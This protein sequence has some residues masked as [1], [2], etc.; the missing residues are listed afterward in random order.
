[1]KAV[2]GSAGTTSNRLRARGYTAPSPGEPSTSRSRPPD[3]ASTRARAAT[4]TGTGVTTSA[5]ANATAIAAIRPPTKFPPPFRS[6]TWSHAVAQR[7]TGCPAATPDATRTRAAPCQDALD[8][9]QGVTAAIRVLERRELNRALLERQ[10]LLRRRR[11]SVLDAVEHLVAMQAPVPARSVRRALVP[12]RSVRS[13]VA[14]R[15]DRRSPR[16]AHDLAAGDAPPGDGSR[17]PGPASARAARRRTH[18]VRLEPAPEGGRRRRRRR[19]L[20]A[21]PR[22]ARGATAHTRRARR[23]D[24]GAVAGPRRVVAR[25]LDVP[26]PDGAGHA[27]RTWGR[28]GPSAFTTVERWLGRPIVAGT[29]PDDMLPGTWLRSGPPPSPTRNTGQAS[30]G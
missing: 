1:M 24:P 14:R 23:R 10:M 4:P 3:G 16:R 27:S 30:P 12:T 2:S 26:A 25:L 9:E 17:R 8:E 21:V 6:A 15:A 11:M 28:T 7:V 13:R 22:A 5:V 29:E 19:A 18:A 20:L